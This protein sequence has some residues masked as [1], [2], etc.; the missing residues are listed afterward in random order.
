MTPVLMAVCLLTGLLVGLRVGARWRRALR[1]Q[2]AEERSRI[3]MWNSNALA[4]DHDVIG[5]PVTPARGEVE[6]FDGARLAE[7]RD[8]HV[9]TYECAGA[10]HDEPEPDRPCNA[11]G[12]PA[13]FAWETDGFPFASCNLCV[14]LWFPDGLPD[15][16]V[17]LDQP[18]SEAECNIGGGISTPN[19]ANAILHPVEWLS[20]R[21][22]FCGHWERGQFTKDQ[23]A[24]WMRVH[25]NAMVGPNDGHTSTASTCPHPCGTPEPE[26]V[27]EGPVWCAKS[28]EG[29]C[30]VVPDVCPEEGTDWVETVCK[31]GIMLPGGYD[32]RRPDCPDCVAMFEAHPLRRWGDAVR[33]PGPVDDDTSDM[34][35]LPHGRVD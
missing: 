18:S 15:H 23:V 24:D 7:M 13:V 20:L 14:E 1:R 6:L 12:R 10:G 34:R 16:V 4:T 29:W 30:A 27:A 21:C 26:V 9:C 11:C 17:R 8:D 33:S 19:E 3:D 28:V 31:V 35:S 25:R 5:G 2:L 22:G 32:H